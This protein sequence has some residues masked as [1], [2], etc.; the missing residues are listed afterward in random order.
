[1][2]V[3]GL[4]W[5]RVVMLAAVLCLGTAGRA[6]A[7]V[8]DFLNQ[9]VTAVS[10]E[11][12]GERSA[13][14]RLVLLLE[15]RAGE[16]LTLNAVRESIGHLFALGMFSDVRVDAV[17][18][19]GGVAVTFRLTSTRQV[20]GFTIDGGAPGIDRGRLRQAIGEQ[21]GDRP[22]LVRVPDIARFLEN[23]M[24]QV[25]YL[26]AKVT[27]SGEPDTTNGVTLVL[28]LE[29]GTRTTIGQIAIQGETGLSEADLRRRLDVATGDPFERTR[30]DSRIDRYLADRRRAGFYEV[31]MALAVQ[32]ADEDH[33]AHLTLTA[34]QGPHVRVVFTGDPLP[35]NRRDDL[36]PVAR[37]GAVDED[38]LE[39]S[40]N[41]IEDYLR[42][43]GYKDAQAPFT[44][45]EHDG[46][47]SL[48]FDVRRGPQYRVSEVAL[49][50]ATSLP[51]STWQ[52]RLRV[53]SGQPFSQTALNGDLAIIEDT[54]RREGFADVTVAAV[55]TNT[56][57]ASSAGDVG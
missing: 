23:E 30:L 27:S 45:E 8:S 2:R 35:A 41:H 14:S 36:V 51:D 26:H 37:E 47:L 49:S 18:E 12:D 17:A 20:T 25:G 7:D 57:G 34:N 55:T 42:S 54:Y 38:L 19:S 50:G 32:L 21:F 43:L 24:Q 13:E 9:P 6:A 33:I 22:R 28:H 52:T 31:R 4:V 16:T 3:W 48:V 29:P 56:P 44:R 11:V 39:D 1:M 40:R 46:E 10:I 5:V 15:V 53:R